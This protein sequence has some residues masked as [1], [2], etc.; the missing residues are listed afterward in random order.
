MLSLL[1]LERKQKNYSHP[2]RI[3]IF[4]FV[5]Y[6]FGTET[7]NTFIHSVVPATQI[8]PDSRPKWAK[9]IPVF[10]PKRRKNPTRWGGTCLYS[11]YKGITPPPPPGIIR[12]LFGGLTSDT[13][14]LKYWSFTDC[15][16]MKI[17]N[18]NRYFVLKSLKSSENAFSATFRK[19]K[20]VEV[21][22]ILKFAIQNTENVAFERPSETG[23]FCV[24]FFCFLNFP[25]HRLDVTN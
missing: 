11:L 5:S 18:S 10:R 13:W 24:C 2:F 19:S 25:Q 1:R 7:V 8:T 20:W 9:C 12:T 16:A 3:R 14:L 23:N 6:S 21:W 22:L 4:L 17:S 15:H